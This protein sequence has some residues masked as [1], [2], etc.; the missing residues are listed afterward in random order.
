MYTTVPPAQQMAPNRFIPRLEQR[1]EGNAGLPNLTLATG[2]LLEFH[3]CPTALWSADRTECLFNS[4]TVALFGFR[5]SDFCAD[6]KLWIA[7]LDE[8]DRD[9]FMSSWQ[10]LQNG[11][12][13]IVCRYRFRPQDAS[14]DIDVEET[15]L[16]LPAGPAGK[17]AVLSW[18]HAYNAALRKLGRN[19]SPVERLIHQ[20]GNNLQAIRSEADLLRL[21]NGLPQRSFDNITQG[22]DRIQ[23][24]VAQ[25]DGAAVELSFE[26]AEAG[27]VRQ[28]LERSDNE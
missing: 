18:Y 14:H 24:L 25:I 21:F 4:A 6:Q 27:E 5:D 17:P 1:A 16:L 3:C 13:K 8:R 20:I 15:A 12:S 26:R 19:G 7:R 2:A 11:E 23:H 28:R 10:S 22:I 9:A